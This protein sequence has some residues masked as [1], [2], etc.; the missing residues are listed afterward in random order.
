L[1]IVRAG[2]WAAVTVS[3]SDGEVVVPFV[4]LAM[5][6]TAPASRSAW[7]IVYVAVQ[8]TEAS[9]A[10]VAVAGHDSS[11]DL[12]SETEKGPSSV[13]LPVFVTR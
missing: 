12:S 4:A 13:T 1:A 2:S 11:V 6:V 10:S 7:L 9:G 5:L 3:L 8:L